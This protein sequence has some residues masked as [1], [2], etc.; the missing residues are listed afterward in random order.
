MK[1]EAQTMAIEVFEGQL[2]YLDTR[3]RDRKTLADL[4]AQ[5]SLGQIQSLPGENMAKAINI[6]RQLPGFQ[7]PRNLE[8]KPRAAKLELLE[9]LG[10]AHLRRGELENCVHNRNV[11]RCIFPIIAAGRHETPRARPEP[12][13]L[14]SIWIRTPR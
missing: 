2:A 8:R 5:Y 10:V 11:D 1:T 12:N 6:L 13:T 7:S 14:R 4:L 9:L 3:K